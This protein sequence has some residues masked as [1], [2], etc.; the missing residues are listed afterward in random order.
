MRKLRVRPS[1]HMG[2][3]ASGFPWA[4]RVAAHATSSEVVASASKA[5]SAAS[6]AA[7]RDSDRGSGTARCFRLSRSRSV[8]ALTHGLEKNSQ[9]L[10]CLVHMPGYGVLAATHDRR[11]LRVAHVLAI[12][13]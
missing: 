6:I 8:I 4:A 7:R 5:V 11:G 13:E 3:T 9:A 12:D 10:S 1:L 2:R